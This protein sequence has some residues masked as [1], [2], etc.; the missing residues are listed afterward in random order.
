ML[1]HK[2]PSQR[3]ML[4]IYSRE[5]WQVKA[6]QPSRRDACEFTSQSENGEDSGSNCQER[7]RGLGSRGTCDHVGPHSGWRV[8]GDALPGHLGEGLACSSSAVIC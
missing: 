1:V 5:H 4:V 2:S 6:K 7:H 3:P 8:V